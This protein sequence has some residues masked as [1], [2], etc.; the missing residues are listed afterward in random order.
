MRPVEGESG[1]LT[2]NWLLPDKE[3]PQTIFGVWVL[4]ELLAG[5]TPLL[6]A[7]IESGLGED[8]AGPGF[9]ELLDVFRGY[10]RSAA[11]KLSVGSGTHQDI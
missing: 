8:L 1:M 5:R 7:L 3:K 2:M 6:Q 9:G 11:G 4:D 10:E